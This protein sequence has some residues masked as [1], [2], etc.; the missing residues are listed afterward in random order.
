MKI[1]YEWDVET[2][3][4][5]GDIQD[6]DH[7]E[8]LRDYHLEVEAP[9]R[10]VLVRDSYTDYGLDRSWAYVE[11]GKLPSHFEDAYGQKIRRIPKRFQ[12]EMDR[13]IKQKRGDS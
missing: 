11:D 13:L 12:F 5:F 3:D 1:N 10:L 2:V 7:S 9:N 8:T 6:H 4:E